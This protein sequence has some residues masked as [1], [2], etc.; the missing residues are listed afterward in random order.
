MAGKD[1]GWLIDHLT[2][3]DPRGVGGGVK[4]Q[5]S[6]SCNASMTITLRGNSDPVF[7][8]RL[9]LRNMEVGGANDHDPHAMNMNQADLEKQMLEAAYK[10][11]HPG[12]PANH[13][14]VASPRD[15]H[16][17]GRFADDLLNAQSNAT[18]LTFKS[19][20]NPSGRDVVSILN[21]SLDAGMQVPLVIG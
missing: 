21:R 16:G 19:V 14:G 17:V 4:Q 10:G 12:S 5:W 13:Q 11:S 1:R 6:T 7:A 15:S 20:E 3:G 2:L 8:L 9:R 18:G